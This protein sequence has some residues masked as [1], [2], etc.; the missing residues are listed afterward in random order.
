MESYSPDCIIMWFFYYVDGVS[1]VCITMWKQNIRTRMVLLRYVLICAIW[2]VHGVDCYSLVCIAMCSLTRCPRAGCRAH[3]LSNHFV[4]H[5]NLA[6]WKST[7]YN[8]LTTIKC[9]FSVFDL[10]VWP[11]PWQTV[12]ELYTTSL[13][14]YDT[15]HY[16]KVFWK[17]NNNLSSYGPNKP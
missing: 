13:H 6:I 2:Y 5:L 7:H 8:S 12:M 10:S 17:Y 16:H 11:L 3:H 1:L 4:V 15:G 9:Q 14:N